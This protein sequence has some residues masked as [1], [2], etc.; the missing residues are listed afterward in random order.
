MEY[1]VFI[2]QYY[3]ISKLLLSSGFSRRLLEEEVSFLVP[4]PPPPPPSPSC[5]EFPVL[6][7]Y[8]ASGSRSNSVQ[9]NRVFVTQPDSS[10]RS[11]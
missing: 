10:A 5:P 8:L 3:H 11:G 6:A 7:G 9:V 4:Y 2:V 1:F